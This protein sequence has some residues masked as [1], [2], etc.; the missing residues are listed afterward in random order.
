VRNNLFQLHFLNIYL[1]KSQ[2]EMLFSQASQEEYMI[3]RE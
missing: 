1:N 2:Y 3:V